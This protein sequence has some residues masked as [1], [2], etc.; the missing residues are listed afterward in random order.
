VRGLFITVEGIDGAGKSTHLAWLRS[1]FETRGRAAV[2]TREP[3]GTPVGE[4]LRALILNP[5]EPLHPET[6]ALMVFA[7]RREHLARVILPALSEGKVVLCDRFTDATY[8]YQGY[9][10]GIDLSKLEV[11]EDWVQGSLRPDITVLLDVPTEIGRQRAAGQRDADRFERERS[12]FFERVR[13]GYMERARR[14][15]QRFI[16]IDANQKPEYV[17]KKLEEYFSALSL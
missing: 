3:G 13:R 15:P 12:E 5:V 10:S 2:L 11:L 17:Q 14:Y 6:E 1:F 16:V 7:A 8:A 4:S 9:G